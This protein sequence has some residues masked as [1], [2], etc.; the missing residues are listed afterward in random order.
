MGLTGRRYSP[1]EIDYLET[2]VGEVP[3]GVLV[4]RHAAWAKA[5]GAPGRT[6]RAIHQFLKSRGHNIQPIG[7]YVRTSAIR[8]ALQ[9]SQNLIEGWVA[10]GWIQ[11]VLAP[12]KPTRNAPRPPGARR[13]TRRA[14]RRADLR[15]MAREHPEAF[16]GARRGPLFILLEDEAL[17]DQIVR[18]FPRRATC[19]F[20]ERPVMNIETRE[21]YPSIRAAARATGLHATLIRASI[22]KGHKAKG[23]RWAD[24]TTLLPLNRQR[25][26][27]GRAGQHFKEAS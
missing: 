25:I 6:E 19:L 10:R 12:S 9:C 20:P 4:R 18:D 2:L 23:T 5:H 24:A 11:P 22:E 7:E 14:F 15:T 21:R 1:E 17:A 16:A 26:S 3:L 8:S 13:R 27:G